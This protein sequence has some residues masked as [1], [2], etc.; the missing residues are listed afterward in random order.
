MSSCEISNTSWNFF[1]FSSSFSTSSTPSVSSSSFSTKFFLSSSTSSESSLDSV[2]ASSSSFL[3]FFLT[4]STFSSVSFL[5]E[6]VLAS[7]ALVLVFLPFSSTDSST[8]SS[9]SFSKLLS[10]FFENSYTIS[11]ISSLTLLALNISIVEPCIPGATL[12]PRIHSAEN[13]ALSTLTLP[14]LSINPSMLSISIL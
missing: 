8:F 10:P 14:S 12:S 1:S 11:L 7:L 5:S 4:S 13:L 9:L 3:A 2:L 6:S